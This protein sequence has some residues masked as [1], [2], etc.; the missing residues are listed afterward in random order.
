VFMG[1]EMKSTHTAWRDVISQYCTTIMMAQK[2]EEF[3]DHE[4]DMFQNVADD[5][6]IKQI[7]LHG[8]EG[9]TNYIYMVGAGHITHYIHVHHNL[10]KFLQ[11]GWESLNLK[12]K[13]LYFCST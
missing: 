1:D 9:I 13:A 6:H 4:I 12:I 3:S 7:V 10:Y 8:H 2:R 5:F 11:Q